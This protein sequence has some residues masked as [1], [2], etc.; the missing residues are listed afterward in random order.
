MA[1]NVAGIPEE[2]GPRKRL[3]SKSAGQARA[4]LK[5]RERDGRADLKWP[6]GR[7][8]ASAAIQDANARCK[9]SLARLA[10]AFALNLHSCLWPLHPHPLLLG[11]L[12]LLQLQ[13]RPVRRRAEGAVR[14][15]AAGAR[16]PTKGDGSAADTI[17][18]GGG[19]PSLLEPSEI[20]AIIARLPRR[21]STWPPTPRSRSK[22]IPRPSRRNGSPAFAPPASI[23]SAY[24]VQSFRDDELQ[25]LSRLHSASRAG[26]AFAMARAAG[27]DNI[28]LDLMMW[29]PQQSVAQWLESVDA[30]I[31]LGPD[32]A[33]LYMLEL[34]PNAPLR[35]AM[36][37]SKWSLAPDD[38]A[39]EMYLEAMTRLDA[40]GYEQY[41]ISNV[42][43]PGRES[44]HNLKYWT[45]G[46][47]LGFGCGAHSTRRGVRWKNLSST[48]GV[49]R[50]CR[51][52]RSARRRS[53]G[54]CRRRSGSRRRSS[55]ACA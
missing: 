28:S 38:D 15:G 41:E 25:R 32:H 17:F 44:R 8:G 6:G 3:P 52:R 20:A 19:T 11:D 1:G 29:L 35:E 24:G 2:S 53:G 45:D 18:F 37:R 48:D 54:S 47:W 31:A 4:Q 39:A 5:P 13:S 33:S 10:V 26:E 51:G 27:F 55:P 30:L 50:R 36:A 7:A 23:V 16:L 49:H 34:Y 14:R 22:P 9:L 43:R 21:R 12:Q 46:E 42:A 40:A